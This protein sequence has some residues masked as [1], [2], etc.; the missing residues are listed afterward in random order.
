M[1]PVRLCVHLPS[2]RF[3]LKH[4][5]RVWF[6][7]TTILKRWLLG[8]CGYGS[9]SNPESPSTQMSWYTVPKAMVG[10][11]LLVPKQRHTR[12]LGSAVFGVVTTSQRTS[13]GFKYLTSIYLHGPQRG[14][15][16]PT[17]GSNG[18]WSLRVLIPDCF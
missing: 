13:K 9:I 12:V 1:R 14:Y 6:F 8:P 4:P 18:T 7:R 2:F 3:W 5:L 11:E 15:H 10:I 17:L 16:L